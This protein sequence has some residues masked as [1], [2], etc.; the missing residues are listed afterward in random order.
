MST[1]VEGVFKMIGV[2]AESFTMKAKRAADYVRGV[3]SRF[4]TKRVLLGLG[5]IVAE[6]LRIIVILLGLVFFHALVLYSTGSALIALVA[7]IC[8]LFA[9]VS[10]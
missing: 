4:P 6:L 7:Y 9:I 10:S 5:I 8:A 3:A 1:T 2:D